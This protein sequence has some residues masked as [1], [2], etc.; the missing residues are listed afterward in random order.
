MRA[1]VIFIFTS[2][3]F[4]YSSC[5]YTNLI[6]DTVYETPM[7]QNLN[8]YFNAL[9]KL[10]KF[11]GVVY[12]QRNDGTKFQK[13]FNIKKHNR[14]SLYVEKDH[15]FDIHS[16]SKLIAKTIIIDLEQ[17]GLLQRTDPLIKYI[18]DFPKGE[19]ITI[20]HM[21]DNTSGL[22]RELKGEDVNTLKMSTKEFIA[23]A[24]KQTLEFEPGTDK[25]YSNV[26]YEL[27]YYIIGKVNNTT[28]VSYLE[29]DLFPSLKMENSGGH[30]YSDKS[31]LKNWAKN[32]VLDGRKI[33]ACEN[34]TS[35]DKR[36]S[37]L[38][39]NAEDLMS[40]L[41]H[42]NQEKYTSTIK[43]KSGLIAWTGGSEG[44]S[45]HAQFDTKTGHKFVML[46]NYDQ[47]PLEDILNNIEKILNGERVALP[48]AT[49][50]I[51]VAVDESVIK[52]YVGVYDIIDGGHII[53]EF[54]LEKGGLVLYQN[55]SKLSNLHAESETVF[56]YD[57]KVD[58][59]FEFLE[60][61]GDWE[62]KMGWKGMKLKGV[63]K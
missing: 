34:I 27:L 32:H 26:A 11:N 52:K 19:E 16:I 5:T 1:T 12:A 55:G 40:F 39:S 15:Q 24:K 46:A 50:R 13:A 21:M 25:R 23:E 20:Q 48:K 10:E 14:H 31:Q 54:K 36:Q 41:E 51:A 33:L 60:V 38:Y 47:I 9:T 62:L 49:N 17:E 56:F 57:K 59:S 18:P 35:E 45:T 22:P 29:N 28:F 7:E 30:F 44:I 3:L 2:I 43:S 4:T 61:E 37:M 8:D 6:D 58:E 53:L 63:K 42:C